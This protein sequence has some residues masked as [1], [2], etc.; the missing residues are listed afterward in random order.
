MKCPVCNKAGISLETT[1]CPDCG[2]DLE[3]VVLV[4][5]LDKS[6]NRIRKNLTMISVVIAILLIAFLI[7]IYTLYK[8]RSKSQTQIEVYKEDYKKE[9]TTLQLKIDSLTK[10]IKPESVKESNKETELNKTEDA[11]THVVKPGD[12]LWKLAQQY[13]GDGN[14]YMKIASDNNLGKPYVLR[15][16]Q[17][18]KIT[19]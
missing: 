14:K 2:S 17:E 6:L 1:T 7:R 18:L 5:R 19:K 3:A 10:L 16:G 15:E 8:D 11:G 12:S 4:A 13:L 9:K